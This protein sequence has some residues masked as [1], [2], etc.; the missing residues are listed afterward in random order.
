MTAV[1]E[2]HGCTPGQVALAWVLAQG[3]DI[4][5][6]PGTKRVSYLEQNIAA[7]QVTL[8]EA[9]LAELATIQVAAP[10]YPDPASFNRSTPPQS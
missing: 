7:A 5:P 4:V 8:N 9:D 6:I 10:R 1:A 3:D 2:R